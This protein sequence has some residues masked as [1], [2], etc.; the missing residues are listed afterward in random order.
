MHYCA[1]AASSQ[2]NLTSLSTSGEVEVAF[3]SASVRPVWPGKWSDTE[4]EG[5]EFSSVKCEELRVAKS[6]DKN[7]AKAYQSRVLSGIHGLWV[8][9][10][11]CTCT[12]SSLLV[13]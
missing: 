5:K 7:V 13:L 9:L 3:V 6:G 12:D 10:P 11:H 8:P 1:A 4:H 2:S